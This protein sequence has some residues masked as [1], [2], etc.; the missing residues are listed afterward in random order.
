[1]ELFGG[2][3]MKHQNKYFDKII[4]YSN[5]TIP[6]LHRDDAEEWSFMMRDVKSI[7]EEIDDKNPRYLVASM[8]YILTSGKEYSIDEEE[9]AY[10]N[11][12]VW[13][14]LDV[15]K[16]LAVDL[17]DLLIN[18]E[19]KIDEE[20][21]AQL[22]EVFE[23]NGIDEVLFYDQSFSLKDLY[24]LQKKM[25]PNKHK[26]DYIE[27][28][29]FQG[30]LTIH[31]YALDIAYTILQIEPFAYH[32]LIFLMDRTLKE[33][34]SDR[35]MAFLEAFVHTYEQVEYE[36]LLQDDHDLTIQSDLREYCYALSS[37]AMFHLEE[38][39]YDK[40]IVYY[41]KLIK[42]DKENLF[43]GREY[44]LRSYMFNNQFDK[45]SD[46]LD[47]LPESNIYK[48]LLTLYRKVQL[49][50]DDMESYLE[51]TVKQYGYLLKILV[52][53]DD[54]A[55]SSLPEIEED[56]IVEYGQLYLEDEELIN[57]IK[58]FLKQYHFTA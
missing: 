7:I 26:I 17:V 6:H 27:G 8:Y 51:E 34:I 15:V 19:Q 40:A 44:A 57:L 10:R 2:I 13:S 46:M 54:E 30:G 53:E 1:M 52:N 55:L 28:L 20:M 14:K 4:K 49:L 32:V 24:K 43:H 29:F 42:I 18:T 37:L 38:E 11:L 47:S 39:S 23:G 50:E 31:Q 41:E 16:D 21:F 58:E 25:T 22:L 33:Q 3:I 36:M 56:F 12:R 5:Q 45:Y 48:R 35:S 9:A